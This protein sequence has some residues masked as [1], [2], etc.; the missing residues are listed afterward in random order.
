MVIDERVREWGYGRY[1]GMT[2][3]QILV[4]R[5]ERGLDIEEFSIWKDGCEDSIDGVGVGKGE[6]PAEMEARIDE[7]IKEVREIQGAGIAEGREDV[8]ILIVGF[9]SIG[10]S[11]LANLAVV[12]RFLTVTF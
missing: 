1:E 9:R 11:A 7:V 3:K 6:S 4:D 12:V 2:P 10:W 5:R 8:N